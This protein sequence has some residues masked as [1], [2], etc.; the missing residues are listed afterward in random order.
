M[1]VLLKHGDTAGVSQY[2]GVKGELI[3]DRDTSIIRI[4]DGVT[5]GGHPAININYTI[6]TPSIT[7]PLNNAT[8]V[9][10]VPILTSSAYSGSGMHTQ[11]E[12]VV[13]RDAI[14]QD[15]V[16]ASGLQDIHKTTLDL[17]S[18]SVALV[19][20]TTYYVGVR[21]KSS[22]GLLS[23]FSE[24]V[25][26]TTRLSLP[27]NL[28]Q[29]IIPAWTGNGAR[30]GSALAL[31]GDGK[32]LVTCDAYNTTTGYIGSVYVYEKEGGDYIYKDKLEPFDLG[33]SVPALFA[34][35]NGIGISRDG[36]TIAITDY[37]CVGDGT[38]TSGCCWVYVKTS[39]V[40]VGQQKI[41]APE[42]TPTVWNN[43]F[44]SRPLLSYDG[45]LMVVGMYYDDEM[46]TNAGA[47]CVFKR[48]GGVWS[49]LQKL[50]PH[51]TD[52]GAQMGRNTIVGSSNFNTLAFGARLSTVS[53]VTQAGRVYV[54][55]RSGDTWVPAANI[56]TTTPSP[57]EAFGSI[58]AISDDGTELLVGA[59]G[60]GADGTVITG[61]V[62][63]Y[64]L[65]GGTWTFQYK[66]QTPNPT[67]GIDSFGHTVAADGSF[68]KLFISAM[69][70]T[71][72][73]P[74]EGAGYLYTKENGAWVYQEKVTA[75]YIGLKMRFPQ[76]AMMSADGQTLVCG[77]SN[78][79]QLFTDSG[80]VYV[81][82]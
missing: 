77:N 51:N 66:I 33:A 15:I 29:T 59:P 56:P 32:V 80:S 34:A 14:L 19:P 55:N 7:G 71:G 38:N 50:K 63:Y 16:Y 72:V 28:Q 26:F 24:V 30:F 9:S 40:W 68:T 6:A 21:Y 74:N 79:D 27:E 25:Q 20:H 45:N 60:T 67:P 36:N 61:T 23:D 2:V 65:I 22:F 8:Q 42:G 58:V 81:Y 54:F 43:R 47:A 64:K 46:G 31:S 62:S 35:N 3:L 41:I 57:Y 12:W 76:T 78:T 13:A 73:N 53:G 75:P 70:E 39:G 49:L 1:K 4:M 52:V 17:N 48:V 18:V 11:S 82:K 37:A 10:C 5:P 69:T 44:G